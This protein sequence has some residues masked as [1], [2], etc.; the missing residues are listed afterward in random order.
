M[1]SLFSF[2]RVCA[3]ALGV[4]VFPAAAAL[5]EDVPRTP[6]SGANSA[7]AKEKGQA[8]AH[9]VPELIGRATPENV[10]VVISLSK[11]R[12]YFKVG[13][14][15]AIDSPVS[16][17]RGARMTPVGQFQIV[18]K[19]ANHRSTLYGKFVGAN[20]RT[21]RSD[22]ST[23][24]HSPPAG[25][26]FQGAPMKWFLRL[27]SHP[28]DFTTVGIHAGILPGYPASHGCIRLP[29]DVAKTIF[30]KVKLGTPVTILQ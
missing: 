5:G 7:R 11:Q 28:Q 27:G 24:V 12:L 22:V 3:V 10:A 1:W 18:Q 9:A 8:T 16:T 20:G 23:R 14:E 30:E 15:T 17:G 4:A 13:H 26:R 2:H 19:V 6:A 21:V 29:K 25:A